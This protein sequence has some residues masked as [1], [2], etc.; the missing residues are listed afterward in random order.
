MSD[1]EQIYKLSNCEIMRIDVDDDHYYYGGRIGEEKEYWIGWT[2]VLDVGG[3]FPEGLRQYLKVTSFEE[4]KERLQVTG[5]RGTKL[6]DA[7]ERL[8][9][10]EELLL[11]PDFPTTYEKDAIVTFIQMWRFLNPGKFDVEQV[12][13]DPDWHVAGTVDFNG[14]VEEWRL[15]C[16][17]DPKRYLELDSD[18]DL[19]LQERWLDIEKSFPSQQR[20]I[21][22]IIDWKFTGR[23]AYSHKVQVAG[24]KTFNNKSRPGRQASRAFIWRYSPVHKFR[25]DFQESLFTYRKECAWVYQTF[26][27]YSGGMPPPPNIRHYPDKVRLYD[28]VKS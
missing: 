4:Q 19:Q 9:R 23:N 5:A 28:K 24:Y 18:G 25:F 26:I 21:R 17:L 6:H 27:A 2:T 15:T 14:F 7:L 22:I 1:T 16:L 8:A 12:V 10:G 13:G 3:P 20:R 11:N